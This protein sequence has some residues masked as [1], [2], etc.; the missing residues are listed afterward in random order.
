MCTY[1]L[2]RRLEL[3][4]AVDSGR[5]EFFEGNVKKQVDWTRLKRLYGGQITFICHGAALTP[6][7]IEERKYPGEVVEVNV[8]GTVRALDFARRCPSLKRFVY[9]TSD[10]VFNVPGLIRGQYD[11]DRDGPHIQ[12]L[13]ATTKYTCEKIVERYRDIFSNLA[14]TVVCA[15]FSDVYG[16]FDRDTGARNR[17]NAPYHI[18]RRILANL[19]VRY[20]G[21]LDGYVADCIFVKDA[22]RAVVAILAKDGPTQ[23]FTYTISLGRPVTLREILSAIPGALDSA[24]TSKPGEIWDV[25]T[26][27]ERHHL[28]HKPY[29]LNSDRTKDEFGWIPQSPSRVLPGYLAR[30]RASKEWLEIKQNAAESPRSSNL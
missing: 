22:A 23:S 2:N 25:A 8:M 3:E 12:P 1:D 29:N 19:P 15:R 17:H 30:L 28:Y 21:S 4:F 24:R 20:V 13:Y 7:S 16:D 6:T 26:E 27:G 9:I 11:T 10:A 18:C 14:A 5:C